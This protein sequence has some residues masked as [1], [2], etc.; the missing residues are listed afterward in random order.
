MPVNI[1][2]FSKKQEASGPHD[3]PRRAAVGSE[4]EGGS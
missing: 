2:R 4:N 3:K 1:A